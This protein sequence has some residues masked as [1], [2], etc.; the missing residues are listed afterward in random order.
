MINNTTNYY[1]ISKNILKINCFNNFFK[2]KKN[3]QLT[4]LKKSLI[5]KIYYCQIAHLE[6]KKK[7]KV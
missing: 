3:H 7:I 5:I 4:K 2:H 6:Q 1:K